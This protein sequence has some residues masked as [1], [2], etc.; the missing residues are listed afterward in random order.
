[1]TVP[2]SDTLSALNGFSDTRTPA[3]VIFRGDFV[4]GNRGKKTRLVKTAGFRFRKGE[5]TMPN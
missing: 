4:V 3:L 1:M 5:F 2:I